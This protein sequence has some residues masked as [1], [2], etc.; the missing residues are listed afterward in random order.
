GTTFN[1]PLGRDGRGARP[2][3]RRGTIAAMADRPPPGLTAFFALTTLLHGAAVLS[4]F[5]GIH[6]ALPPV[7]HAAILCG[8]LPLLLLEGIFLDR[9]LAAHDGPDLPLWMRVPAGPIRSAFAL[10]LTYLGLFTLQTWD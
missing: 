1:R 2:T 6:A 3:G 5:D 9:L 10:A 7:V 4:R 8:Q